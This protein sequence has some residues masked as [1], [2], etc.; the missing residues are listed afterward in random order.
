MDAA[1]IAARSF[2]LNLPFPSKRS[3]RPALKRVIIM[4]I[5]HDA[6][7]SFGILRMLASSVC[8]IWS[9]H[10]LFFVRFFWDTPI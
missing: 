8:H 3:L 9:R 5:R 10:A 4:I 2:P 7:L 1:P 6:L